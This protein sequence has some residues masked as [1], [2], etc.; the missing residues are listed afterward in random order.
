VDSRVARGEVASVPAEWMV[1]RDLDEDDAYSVRVRDPHL[2]QA[3][4]LSSWLP[5]DHH[6]RLCQAPVLGTNVPDL[7][8]QPDGISWW[9]RRPTTHLEQTVSQEEHETGHVFPA[10]LAVDRQPQR[11]PVEPVTSAEVEGTQQDPASEDLHTAMI[12]LR[13]SRRA[14]FRCGFVP[15]KPGD[16]ITVD[17][18]AACGRAGRMVG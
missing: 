7:D 18:L 11:V 17:D 16:P 10:E 5:Q 13:L 9:V 3:P 1:L 15:S 4:R 8:P 2:L 14:P 6:T 12:H